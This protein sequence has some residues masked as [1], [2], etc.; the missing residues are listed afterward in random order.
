MER[1]GDAVRLVKPESSKAHRELLAH[2]LSAERRGPTGFASAAR[3]VELVPVAL[4][5]VP[6]SVEE[7]DR[8]AEALES[9]PALV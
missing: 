5:V 4:L 9:L 7:L 2:V 1:E 3:L 8:A 6:E